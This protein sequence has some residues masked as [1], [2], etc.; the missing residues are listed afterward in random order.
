MGNT[1]IPNTLSN[2]NGYLTHDNSIVEKGILVNED[3][4]NEFLN[5]PNNASVI[6][7]FKKYIREYTSELE[8]KEIY[9]KPSKVAPILN[10]YYNEEV[11]FNSEAN[12]ILILEALQGTQ[13]VHYTNNNF[14]FLNNKRIGTNE[15]KLIDVLSAETIYKDYY[16]DVA[17]GTK[18]DSLYGTDYSSYFKDTSEDGVFYVNSFVDL[19]QKTDP[20]EYWTNDRPTKK[21]KSAPK[22]PE[23]DRVEGFEDVTIKLE[24]KLLEIKDKNSLKH[25]TQLK[26]IAQSRKVANKVRAKYERKKSFEDARKKRK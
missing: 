23:L 14:D 21:W 5:D 6:D 2:L 11:R 8:F 24:E 25:Q 9:Y 10:D 16:I 12:Q 4:V 22:D 1:V 3:N 13:E 19:N 18:E 7:R 20:F 17:I 15:S 26:K